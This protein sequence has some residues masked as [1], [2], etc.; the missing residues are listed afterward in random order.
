MWGAHRLIKFVLSIA[1]IVILTAPASA[2]TFG[3]FSI[4]DRSPNLALLVG[5]ITSQTP[6]DFR[7]MMSARPE[8]EAI[9]LWSDGGGMNPALLLADDIHAR[10][11][12][13]LI[14]EGAG[15]YSACAY[16]YLAGESRLAKGKLGV[17]Q[18]YGGDESL[19]S[20]QYAVSDILDILNQFDVPQAVIT[21]MLRTDPDDMYIFSSTE[22]DELGLNRPGKAIVVAE[23]QWESAQSEFRAAIS[24]YQSASTPQQ[25][26]DASA[27]ASISFALYNGVDFYG[28]DVGEIRADDLGQC[29]AACLENDQCMA[30]TLNT[31][32][33]YTT[34][35]NCF[36]KTGIGETKFYEMAVS[37]QFRFEGQPTGI[38][39]DGRY[40]PAASVVPLD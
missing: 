25:A 23:E 40:V 19:S 15:C 18:F 1:A 30:I 22:V 6:L 26:A 7:R 4:S 34:G 11:L 5:D 21:Q 2:E 13:T 9:A 31:N 38:M 39:V 17:H 37:G 32:P 24:A 14:P 8:V 10:G 27:A 12:S 28:A 35:P 33:R 16:L 20:A 29:Y 3:A 36:L